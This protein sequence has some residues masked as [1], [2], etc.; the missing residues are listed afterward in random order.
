MKKIYLAILI[1]L[2]LFAQAQSKVTAP[3]AIWPELQVSTELSEGSLLFFKNGY[4]INTDDRFNDLRKTGILSNFERIELTVGYEQTLS[5]HWRGG[6]IVRYAIEDYP[7]TQ[8]Y[9]LFMRHNGHIES[10]Y[11]NKQFTAEYVRQ[12]EQ[13]PFGRFT[14]MAEVGKRLPLKNK[15]ITPSITFDAMVINDFSK[16]DK[17]T[18]QERTIDRTRLRLNLNYELTEKLRINPYFMRQTDYYYMLVSPVYDEQGKLIKEGY[19]TKR[20]RIS[21]VF[22]LELKYAINFT[23]HTAS[24]TY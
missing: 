22:G 7:K 17:F 6:A 20:N 8:F 1:L 21:P 12:E 2:P 24:I 5:D 13:D 9:T 16:D 23:P 4:R 11:F 15:F 3:S 19:T 18:T 10:L 14:A